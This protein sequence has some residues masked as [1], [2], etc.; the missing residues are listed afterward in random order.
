MRRFASLSLLNLLLRPSHW[1]RNS[2]S[3]R[4]SPSLPSH[5]THDSAVPPPRKN[6]GVKWYRGDWPGQLKHEGNQGGDRN[7]FK[8]YVWEGGGY[9]KAHAIL[10]PKFTKLW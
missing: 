5:A 4:C 7:G 6:A 10:A 1:T 9:S 2:C 3:H 8:L